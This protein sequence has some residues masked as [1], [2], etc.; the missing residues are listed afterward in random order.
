MCCYFGAFSLV[1]FHP[2][3]LLG[4]VSNNKPTVRF[5]CSYVISTSMMKEKQPFIPHLAIEFNTMEW[6][7]S[8]SSQSPP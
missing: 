1:L 3:T 4:E 8:F 6:A 5:P 7:H 2:S